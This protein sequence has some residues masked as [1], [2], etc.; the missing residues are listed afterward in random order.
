MCPRQASNL[1]F[2]LRGVACDFR[3][4]PRTV[5]S[6][7]CGVRSAELTT[8]SFS[9]HFAFRT[10]HSKASRPGLEPGPGPSEGPMRSA[11]PSGQRSNVSP[12][13]LWGED[14]G[15]GRNSSFPLST[16]A[17]IRTLCGSFGGCSLSQEHTRVKQV[18]GTKPRQ[19]PPA[20]Q[21]RA[22]TSFWWAGT[23]CA[24]WSHP[25]KVITR[26]TDRA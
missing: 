17:R 11:T 20:H 12:S 7:E 16:S 2:D 19:R 21:I 9:P 13:P 18:G 26:V 6:A 1:V 25:T 24:S 3:H 5:S 22:I 15:E 4:T 8:I 10:P 23:R 14:R